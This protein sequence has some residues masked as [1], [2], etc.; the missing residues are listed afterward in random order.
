M[1][2]AAA[3]NES[4]QAPSKRSAVKRAFAEDGANKTHVGGQALIEGV[5]MRGR[6][7]WAAA[8]R[9]PSGNIYIEE[10]DLASG[11]AKNKWL[12]WPVVRG[13]RAFVE[14]LILG[15]KALE[16]AAMHAYGDEEEPG[17]K[18]EEA[19]ANGAI[20][21]E[22][23]SVDE[24]VAGETSDFSWK[25]D[26]GNPDEAID[27]LGAQRSLD[28]V[29]ETNTAESGVVEPNAVEPGAAALESDE[30][31]DG[32]DGGF[33]K[34]EM[35]ISMVLGLLLGVGLFIVAPAFIANVLVGEYDDKTLLW[36]VVDGIVRIVVFVFYIWL[37][38]R[39]QDIKRMFSY[40]GAE[41]KTIHCYE[42]GLPLTPENAR[43]FPRLHVRC[44]TAFLIMVMIIAIFVYTITPLNGLIAAW[45]VPDGP[46]KL[47]LVIVARILLMP[48]IAGISY[49]ITVKWAGSHP[50]NPLVK[51]VLWP[52]MQ[53]QRLT[54]NEPD[55]EML[56]CAIAAMQR[57]LE[58][59][60]REEAARA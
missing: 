18:A 6:Y 46:A 23:A 14:S 35:A 45:G 33:G 3:E 39:M 32:D 47:A 57:V 5:M 34:R 20:S 59:E 10:H 55:D 42:H 21:K 25:N 50:E 29:V 60:E 9:E 12:Y 51:V 56:E 36:N 49:E 54:T 58:R 22:G 27:A 24:S 52:G 40:H 41:H 16:I 28:I 53:M 1:L 44:G 2:G 48:V 8:V 31:R 30:T 4:G 13:C 7:N 17:A 43:S 15:Y 38:G 26:F 37:I 11:K 19:S